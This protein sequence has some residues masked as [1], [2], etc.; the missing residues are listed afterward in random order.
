MGHY[1]GGRMSY[2]IIK[3]I[4]IIG[5]DKYLIETECSNEW[6]VYPNWWFMTHERLDICISEGVFQWMVT[7]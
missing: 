6:P 7:A 5:E 2:E 1:R 3:Q 4:F